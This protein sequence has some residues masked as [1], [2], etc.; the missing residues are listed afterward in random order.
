MAFE[1]QENKVMIFN[2]QTKNS[3]KSPVVTGKVNV[4]GE[5]IKLAG[6]KNKKGE[7]IV[8]QLSVKNGNEYNIVGNFSFKDVKEKAKEKSPD[9]T[10]VLESGDKKFKLALWKQTSKDGL[11]HFLSG[12]IQDENASHKVTRNVTSNVSTASDDIF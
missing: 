5:T 1:L 12:N 3:L 9:K 11:T 10:G 2:N 7:G 8:G 4:G 6:W